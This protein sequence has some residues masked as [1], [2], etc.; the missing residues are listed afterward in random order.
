MGRPVLLDDSRSE[1]ARILLH[2]QLPPA[3][4]EWMEVTCVLATRCSNNNSALLSSMWWTWEVQQAPC[5]CGSWMH[6][7]G[8]VRTAILSAPALQLLK[9]MAVHAE[10]LLC[11]AAASL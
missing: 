9:S 3:E 10:H 7:P 4:T 11:W 5:P 6:K 8:P 2:F 1:Q